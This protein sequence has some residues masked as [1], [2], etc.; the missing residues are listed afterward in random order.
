MGTLQITKKSDG[1]GHHL[2][3]IVL[4]TIQLIGTGNGERQGDETDPTI[5]VF[6]AKSRTNKSAK[7]PMDYRES[8]S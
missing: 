7:V 6:Q 5:C 1:D 3:V 8:K 2:G 4:L